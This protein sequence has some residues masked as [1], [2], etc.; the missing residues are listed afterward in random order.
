VVIS[1]HQ[2]SYLLE[3]ELA[4]GHHQI[5]SVVISSHQWPYLLETELAGGLGHI[6]LPTEREVLNCDE[7][8]LM[9]GPRL[10]G[11]HEL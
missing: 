3:T 9:R 7:R 4:G 8:H 2:W 10:N 6:A 1:G 11:R 5:S